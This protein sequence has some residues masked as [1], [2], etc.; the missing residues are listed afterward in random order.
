[1]AKVVT[2]LKRLRD[3]EDSQEEEEGEGEGE[4]LCCVF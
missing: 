3:E 4:A 2:G 1:M